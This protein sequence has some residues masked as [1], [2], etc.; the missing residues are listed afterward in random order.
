[1][2]EEIKIEPISDI[3]ADGN[4]GM[5]EI[6]F[7]CLVRMFDMGVE[8]SNNLLPFKI[9]REIPRK[10]Q[11]F[12]SSGKILLEQIKYTDEYAIGRMIKEMYRQLELHI[13]HFEEHGFHKDLG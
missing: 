11:W 1:M 4:A 3:E 10:P 13:S 7:D 2:N 6:R 8:K 5:C 9:Q 12:R